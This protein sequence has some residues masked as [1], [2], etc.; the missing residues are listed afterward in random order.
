MIQATSTNLELLAYN[1]HPFLLKHHCSRLCYFCL[2]K[3]N[4]YDLSPKFF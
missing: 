4:I 1:I 3:V 2:V